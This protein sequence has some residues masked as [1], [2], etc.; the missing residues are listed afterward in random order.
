[1]RQA[2]APRRFSLQGLATDTE[3]DNVDSNLRSQI[4][5]LGKDKADESDLSG[6]AIASTDVTWS[7]VADQPDCAN[8]ATLNDYSDLKGR[9]TTF[10]DLFTVLGDD[11]TDDNSNDTI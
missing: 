9:V 3:L 1:M 4:N 5:T 11:L 10:G 8:A 7:D 6:F 2:C